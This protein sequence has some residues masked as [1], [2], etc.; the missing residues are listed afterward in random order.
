M[1]SLLVGLGLFESFFGHLG[2][3]PFNPKESD[4]AFSGGSLGIFLILK[5]FSS[6]AVALTGVEAISNGVPAFRRPESRNAAATLVW[7]G[8]ILGTLF[9]GVQILAHHLGPYLS[10]HT[11]VM[12]QLGTAVFGS[13]T[14][15]Y[16]VLQFAT[17]AILTL[18]AN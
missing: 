3:V 17:A 13:G 1:V 11:T 2:H 12:S 4:V 16:V 7:M 10:E 5:G 14:V 9:M 15:L 18:A 6:G 8:I